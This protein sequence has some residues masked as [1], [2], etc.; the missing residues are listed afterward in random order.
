ML[1]GNILEVA[2][3]TTV[4][5]VLLGCGADISSQWQLAYSNISAAFNVEVPFQSAKL[6]CRVVSHTQLVA[7]ILLVL[8]LLASLVGAV[9]RGEKVDGDA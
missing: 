3:A 2:L 9:L 5:F 6:S 8:V 4:I 7:S 1:L